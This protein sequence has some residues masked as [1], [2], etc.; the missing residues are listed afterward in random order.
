M[1]HRSSGEGDHTNPANFNRR[2]LTGTDVLHCTV[3]VFTT[4]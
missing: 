1:S 4:V 2:S 3:T